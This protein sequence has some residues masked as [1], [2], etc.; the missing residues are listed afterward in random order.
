MNARNVFLSTYIVGAMICC[1]V[2]LTGPPEIRIRS[3]G[4]LFLILIGLMVV[5]GRHIF[6]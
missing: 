4:V 1:A 5:F 3:S 2:V 6:R